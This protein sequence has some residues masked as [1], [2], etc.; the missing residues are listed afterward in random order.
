MSKRLWPVRNL[1]SGQPENSFTQ[2]GDTENTVSHSI[3]KDTYSSKKTSPRDFASKDMYKYR[4]VWRRAVMKARF[5]RTLGNLNEEILLYGTSNEVD[6]AGTYEEIIAIKQKKEQNIIAKAQ[7]LPWYVL[8]PVSN[9]ANYWGVLVAFM[10]IYTVTMMPYRIG[11]EDPV[12]FDAATVFDIL[13][14]FV[15][16]TDAILNC[17]MSYKTESG[18]YETSLK[19]IFVGYLKS[20]LLP[21]FIG[22]I[23]ITL[24]EAYQGEPNTTGQSSISKMARLPRLYKIFR[25]IRFSKI[26]NVY[27]RHP[28]YIKLSDFMDIH[29]YLVKLLKFLF[30][31][32]ICVHNLAC[33]WHFAAKFNSFNDD[34]W[35]VRIGYIDKPNSSRYLASMYWTVATIATVGYGDISAKTDIELIFSVLTMGIGVAFYSMIISSVTSLISSIDVKEA[36]TAAKL[37]Q[38][39]EFG[40]EVGLSADVLFKIRKIIRQN[41]SN[42]AFNSEDLFRS[43]PKLLKYEVAMSMYNG[44]AGVMP[45][46]QGKDDSF[47][48]SLFSK[49]KPCNLADDMQLYTAGSIADEI[50]FII[51]GRIELV[52]PEFPQAIY[53]SYFKGSYYGEIELLHN[54]VRLDSARTCVKTQ[55]LY[56]KMEDFH[57]ILNEFVET[58]KEFL[59]IALERL[60]RNTE[61]K[62]NIYELLMQR[63]PEFKVDVAAHLKIV[64]SFEERH[65]EK[66]KLFDDKIIQADL[67]LH[68]SLTNVHSEV[69]EIK[70]SLSAL[71]TKLKPSFPYKRVRL[72]PILKATVV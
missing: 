52:I 71:L 57:H 32:M 66:P 48:V 42:L 60:K 58:Q 35:V 22:C 44:I 56:L 14:D 24:I 43:M 46:L 49:L 2:E 25:V 62:L 54:I 16:I 37:T 7:Q 53:K 6:E 55:L 34:T 68:D 11:F 19:T 50:Y 36:K 70:E 3:T 17:F 61:A 65:R 39:V 20:W 27:K 63:F 12:Y 64:E 1:L 41:A 72:P 30:M 26:V 59:Q 38:A 33:L 8:S 40:S 31:T 15:F 10:L 4:P 13:V 18:L 9:F 28:I 47:V 29:T 51:K 69:Y 45:L 21:D 5:Q 23:P 67:E